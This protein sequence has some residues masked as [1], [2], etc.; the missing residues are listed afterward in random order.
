MEMRIEI[1]STAVAFIW[2]EN[3][4]AARLYC[5]STGSTFSL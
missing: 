4:A 1:L 3:S 2:Q 5:T